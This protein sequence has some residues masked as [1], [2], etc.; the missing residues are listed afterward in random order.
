MEELDS[1][2]ENVM[3][4]V[5]LSVVQFDDVLSSN[6]TFSVDCTTESGIDLEKKNLI[7]L[8]LRDIAK[9]IIKETYDEYTKDSSYLHEGVVSSATN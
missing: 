8:F 5:A 1:T 4:E 2:K 6:S 3:E 9:K 7:K